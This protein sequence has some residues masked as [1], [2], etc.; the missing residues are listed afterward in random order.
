[1]T[2]SFSRAARRQGQ[3][4]GV[5]LAGGR[6]TRMG[7]GDKGLRLLGGQPMLAHV[8]ARLAPQVDALALNANGDAARFAGFGLPVIADDLQDFPGPLAGVLAGMQWA[9]GRGYTAILT[10]AADTPFLPLDLGVRLA[11]AGGFAL[12]AA[13]VDGELRPHPT[14]ALWPVHLRQALRADLLAGERRMTRWALAAGAQLVAFD[15]ADFFNV[16]TPDD[17]AQAEARLR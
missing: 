10:A 7:G 17:L 5:I 16:N 14:Q 13:P 12:A 11:G 1:M 15:P 4:A 2:S 6:A 8:I 9:A 3:I